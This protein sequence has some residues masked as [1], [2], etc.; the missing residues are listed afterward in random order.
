MYIYSHTNTVLFTEPI[1]FL[2][3]SGVCGGMITFKRRRQVLNS[4]PCLLCQ[5]F[6]TY[7]NDI[8]KTE[9]RETEEHGWFYR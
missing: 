1:N 5:A 8:T 7:Q 9:D 4:Q 2:L 6:V 3:G